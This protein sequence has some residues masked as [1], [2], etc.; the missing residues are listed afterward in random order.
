ME[1]AR[2]LSSDPTILLLDEFTPALDTVTEAEV[3]DSIR[4][5][6]TTCVIVAHRLSTVASC[7]QI[8]VM[9]G[10]RI[11][12]RGTHEELF[13]TEGLYRQLLQVPGEA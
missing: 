9:D 6:G 11:V 12:Q 13:N 1:L 7:D 5:K 2:A 8:L 3:F 10:G 4:Q